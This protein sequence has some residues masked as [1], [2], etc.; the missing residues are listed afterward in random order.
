MARVVISFT[1]LSALASTL[2]SCTPKPNPEAEPGPVA[3]IFDTDMGPDYDDVGAIALLHALA[4]SGRA[5]ILGTVA[6]T[7]YEGVASVLDIFNTYFGRPDLPVGV[8]K[9]NALSMR[10]FQH[11]SDT[12]ISRYPHN[13]RSN[14]DAE[15]AV[16]L[17]RR[18]LAGQPDHSVTIITVGFLTNI[19]DLLHSQPDGISSLAGRELV[20][21]KVK[22]LVSMAG[23]FPSGKEFNV[24]KDAASSKFVFENIDRP[25]LFSGF[26]IG[27]K[28]RTG[29]PLVQDAS[30]KQSP[31]KDVFRISIPL[32]EGDRDGRMSWDQTAV[33]VAIK[34][35]KPWYRTQR[36]TF[37]VADDGSNSWVDDDGPH[38]YLIEARPS[39]DV[40]Q[41]IN[42][43]MKHQP[44]R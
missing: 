22:Q 38:Q 2:F 12:L 10:D 14:A 36:G 34:G 26:E 31:V 37:T 19:A 43:L 35:V 30:I 15:D 24:E 11:W 29:L 8:P 16:S 9:G 32:A 5:E 4:D 20:K 41:L 33:F 27:V 1:V 6:S 23:I 21:K 28:I 17:Y 25:I 13:L 39:E 44:R 40:Q 7:K 3:V 42:D 18:I